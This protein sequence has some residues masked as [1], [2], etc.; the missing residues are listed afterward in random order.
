MAFVGFLSVLLLSCVSLFGW[1]AL[2]N[3]LTKHPVRN[4]VVVLTVGLAA[5]IFF[6]GVLNLLRLAYGWAF[7][8]LILAGILLAVYFRK[9][10]PSLPQNRNEWF[11]VAALGLVITLIM[12]FTI[13]TQLPPRAYNYH[14][15]YEKYFSH[16]VRMLQTGTLSGSSLTAIGIQT[17]GGQAFLHGIILNHLPVPYINGADAV[18]GLLL[19]LILPVSIVPLRLTFLPISLLGLLLVFFICPQFVNVS[20][21][22]TGSAF[23]MASILLFSHGDETIGE[24]KNNLPSP[25]LAGLLAAALVALKSSFLLFSALHVAFFCIALALFSVA[26]RRI[27]RWGLSAVLMTLFF[28]SPWLLLHLPHYLRWSNA[29]AQSAVAVSSDEVLNLF[30]LSPL[31]YGASFAHYTVVALSI[32][33]SAFAI[34][35]WKL[36][37][38]NPSKS[39]YFAG[40]GASGAAIFVSYLFLVKLG[41]GLVDYTVNLRYTIPFLIAG[42][43]AVI[44]LSCVL[45]AGE[46]SAKLKN[47]LVAAMLSL[48]LLIIAGFSENL[49]M[50]IRQASQSGNI[51]AF[52]DLAARP[53]FLEY[54]KEVLYGGTGLRIAEAQKRVPAGRTLVTWVMT[55]FY[56]DFKR[57][58]IY[59]ADPSGLDSPWTSMP[60]EAEYFMIEYA[61]LAVRPVAVYYDD[62]NYAGRQSAALRCLDFLRHVWALRKDADVLYDD[63]RIIVFKANKK[64]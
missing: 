33:I 36:I 41:S 31:F 35:L 18:F 16:P 30:S 32:V 63:G 42:A 7:D 61:G 55:P 47:F 20:S 15:D 28:L 6:G 39:V 52:S 4:P 57:N 14:D 40:I 48:A 37:K 45:A 10:R 58:V 59:D 53:D 46:A 25:I 27:A 29:A 21:L 60:P 19:C 11:Y 9:S 50:R 64:S 56:L 38:R 17:L 34:F 51:L 24:A 2:V 23:M 22:Y 44:T 13:S 8:G 62:L 26:F 43:P 12:G 5:L 49:M 54:N 3:R 1:G